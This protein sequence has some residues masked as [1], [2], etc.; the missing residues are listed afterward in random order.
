MWF[1]SKR[2]KQK[3]QEKSSM[4]FLRKGMPER[5]RHRTAERKEG[6]SIG[7]GTLFLWA[8]F[9]GTLFYT[10]FFSAFFLIASPRITGMSEISEDTLRGF[11][12]KELSIKYLRIFPRN[13]F[14]LVRSQNLEERLRVEYPLLASTSV[15]RVFP[16]S[17]SIEVTERKKIIL[18]Y[19]GDECYLIDEEGVAHDSTQALLPENREYVL[20]I[21]DMSNKQVALGEKVFDASYGAFVIQVNELFSAQL[22]LGLEPGYT[23]VSRFADELRVKT[24]EGWE[25]Y[26]GTG[27]PIESSLSVLKLLIEKE[28]PK[29]QRAK[30]AYI[31]L[32]AET[33]AYYAFREGEDVSAPAPVFPVLTEEK[34]TDV[35]SK[36]KK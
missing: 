12:D 13:N 18:W 17:L 31:D 30:L 9:F 32:R 11:I 14:F 28:L 8:L 7:W 3:H 24:D 5:K 33:R 29:E 4:H 25:A 26:F 19:S 35:P 16:N 20:S 23:T 10:A 1:V 21:T 15:T 34:K 27:I 6:R 2:T 36:K 22:G